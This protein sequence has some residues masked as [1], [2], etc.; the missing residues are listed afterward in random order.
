MRFSV[1]R[2][3][4]NALLREVSHATPVPPSQA[5]PPFLLIRPRFRVCAIDVCERG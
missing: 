5:P 1:S 2:W 4:Q 3:A